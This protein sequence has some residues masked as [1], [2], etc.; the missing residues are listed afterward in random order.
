MES[1]KIN[2]T[3]CTTLSHHPYI[4]CHFAAT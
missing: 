2:Q 1:S 3:R 4:L